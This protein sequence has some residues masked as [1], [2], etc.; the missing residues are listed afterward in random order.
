MCIN[1]KNEFHKVHLMDWNALLPATPAPWL[2]NDTCR[3][4]LSLFLAIG[5]TL[6]SLIF[7]GAEAAKFL[8]G[9]V[10]CD[11]NEVTAG[12]WRLGAHCNPKGRAQAS[13][14][15]FAS[16]DS[17]PEHQTITLLLPAGMAAPTEQQLKKFA[18]FSKVSMQRPAA[19][20]MS[21]AII[22][23]GREAIAWLHDLGLPRLPETPLQGVSDA[24]GVQAAILDARQHLYMLMC[25]P[26][27]LPRVLRKIPT[28]ATLALQNGW[29]QCLTALGQAH[30]IPATQEEFI[31]QELNYDLIQGISFKKGCYKGQEIVARLHFKGTPKFRTLRF[32]VDSS[33]PVQAGFH[34]NDANGTR[35]GQIAQVARTGDHTY[36]ILLVAKPDAVGEHMSLLTDS[37]QALRLS[38]LPLSTEAGN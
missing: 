3:N 19:T 20:D 26:T 14:L 33:V 4:T 38:R 15:A 5:D 1:F 10:T 36:D 2:P 24:E 30:V 9:Q 32:S 18:M 7:S 11:M 12:H 23:G 17:T 6:E 31:P 13:F 27:A 37:G 22:V 29:W 21:T 16:A 25:P 34:L 8:Q 35:V 28:H